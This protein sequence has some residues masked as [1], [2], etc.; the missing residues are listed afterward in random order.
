MP[1]NVAQRTA[2]D[3]D[4][5]TSRSAFVVELSEEELSILAVHRLVKGISADYLEDLIT[6]FFRIEP[7]AQDLLALPETAAPGVIGLFTR[8]GFRLLHPL[9]VV[10]RAAEDDLDASRLKV[11]LEGLPEHELIYQTGWDEATTAVRAGRADAAFLLRP[12]PVA[13]I[14]RVADD[15]RRMPPKSTFFQ[16]K[17]L[18]GMAY[19]SLES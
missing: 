5:T 7:A 12:V 11:A 6:P 13:R 14:E 9:A 3:P 17:P 16:P 1:P 15:R 4:P 8:N 2:T 10:E 19:R 18:T